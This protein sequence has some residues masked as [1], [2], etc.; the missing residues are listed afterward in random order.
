MNYFKRVSHYLIFS[1]T[2]VAYW[3]LHM[4]LSITHVQDQPDSRVKYDLVTEN[5]L[6]DQLHAL[7]E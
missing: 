6:T 7:F 3:L 2:L 1:Q 4:Q 5:L